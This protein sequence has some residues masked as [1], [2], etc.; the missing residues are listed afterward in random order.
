MLR[1]LSLRESGRRPRGAAGPAAA[2]RVAAVLYPAVGVALG[3]AFCV[4]AHG[5]ERVNLRNGFSYDCAR[6]EPLD[7]Q[8]VRLYFPPSGT[9]AASGARA[10]SSAPAAS[11]ALPTGAGSR[12][13][14]GSA[15]E[16]FI[17][18]SLQE[19]VSVESLPDPPPASAPP[20]GVS[21]PAGVSV[22]AAGALFSAAVIPDVHDLLARAGAQHN[23]DVELL[24]SVV[25][26]ESGGRAHAVS[27][28]GARGLMQLMPSTAQELGVEDAFRPDQNIAGGAAYLD[29]LLT[30][31]HNDLSLALAAYNAGPAAVD[32][33]RGIPPFR[34][35]RAYVARV[36]NEF[37]R[38]KLA[39]SRTIL[40]SR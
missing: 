37:K 2:G 7:S 25:K 14:D 39:L 1:C 16:N 34:E 11:D 24:A 9:P 15:A 30:R 23:I 33:Y 40:A 13:G 27:H 6:S 8:H 31:Y 20:A 36:E 5:L 3:L 38:R 35:T 32:R 28:A 21:L 29:A 22:S 17:D 19:I 12:P 4:P 18:L 10:T 26:A